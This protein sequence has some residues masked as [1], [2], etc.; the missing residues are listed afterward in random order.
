MAALPME[1]HAPSR[2]VPAVPPI[3]WASL[4]QDEMA[5][6]TFCCALAVGDVVV[7]GDPLSPPHPPATRAKTHGSVSPVSAY[8]RCICLLTTLCVRPTGVAVGASY[9]ARLVMDRALRETRSQAKTVLRDDHPRNYLA[10][11]AWPRLRE[12]ANRVEVAVALQNPA[13]CAAH[14]GNFPGLWATTAPSIAARS[15]RPPATSPTPAARRRRGLRFDARR[16]GGVQPCP[17]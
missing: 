7:V 11:V 4:L 16:G 5:E 13:T 12:P 14:A 10:P 15:P 8:Q 3:C 9:C 6:W 2:A 1:V 17:P